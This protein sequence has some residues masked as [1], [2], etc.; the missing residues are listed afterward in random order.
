MG[1]KQGGRPESREHRL[2]DGIDQANSTGTWKP[3]E[4]YRSAAP[5]RENAMYR[6]P[7]AAAKGVETAAAEVRNLNGFNRTVRSE[8]L[9]RKTPL[10]RAGESGIVRL[11]DALTSEPVGRGQEF[12]EP[13]RLF[14]FQITNSRLLASFRRRHR[15]HETIDVASEP[16]AGCCSPR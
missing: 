14:S 12:T 15:H 10:Y 8:L 16:K 4:G 9:K 6:D 3:N 13:R 7:S 5:T 2:F 11:H 1:A